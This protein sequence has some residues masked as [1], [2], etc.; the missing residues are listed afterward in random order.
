M[1]YIDIWIK[2]KCSR[3]GREEKCKSYSA[4]MMVCILNFI[5]QRE[6]RKEREMEGKTWNQVTI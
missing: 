1:S 4:E 6:E 5:N 2:E 3:C